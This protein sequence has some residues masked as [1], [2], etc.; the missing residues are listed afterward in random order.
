MTHRGGRYSGAGRPDLILLDLNMPRMGGLEALAEIKR[1]EELRA[2]PVVVLTTSNAHPDVQSS[3]Q[4]QASAFVTK[5]MDLDSFEAA[6]WQ[7][8]SFY[9]ETAQL[10][11]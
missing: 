8:R 2:I 4:H 5:P 9:S 6:V 3:Y 1:D 10:P 7:I 11:E